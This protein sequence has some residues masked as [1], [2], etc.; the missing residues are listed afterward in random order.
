G[1]QSLSMPLVLFAFMTSA[2]MRISQGSGTVAM[3]TGASLTAPVAQLMGVTDQMTAL[4][5]IAI[6]CGGTAFSHV[7]DSGFWMANRYFGMSVSD[8]LK[9]WTV[10]KTLVG[11]TGLL[12]CLIISPFI[13]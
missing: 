2:V 1:M 8:T 10:M 5:V 13:S 9:S 3:I 11:L 4:L 7:N 6:A 12:I